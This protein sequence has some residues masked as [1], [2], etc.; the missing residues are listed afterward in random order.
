MSLFPIGITVPEVRDAIAFEN[1]RL[2]LNM[3]FEADRGDIIIFNYLL[4]VAGAFPV[5]SG[6]PV[7][8]R[9]ASIL[10]ECRGLTFCAHTGKVLARKF[11]KFF[12]V[13]ERPETQ[14]H[15]IDWWRPHH[16]LTK[17]DGSMLTPVLV[18]GEL[19]WHTKMGATDVATPAADFARQNPS[20]E[21]FARAL[22][23]G[24]YT[25]AAEWTSRKQRIVIDYPQDNIVF[26]AARDNFTGEYLPYDEL[27]SL[28]AVYDVPVVDALSSPVGDIEAFIAN[29]R[30]LKDI[31]G[32]VIAFAN[33]ER[34][35]VKADDYMRVHKAKDSI[36]LEKSVVAL[37]ANEQV[38]DLLAVLPESDRAALNEFHDLIE[39]GL[40]KKA[41]EINAIVADAKARM[42]K[43]E[44]AM[45][46]ASNYPKIKNFLFSVWDGRDANTV[47]RTHVLNNT[48]SQTRVD[49]VRH[50][51]GSARWTYGYGVVTGD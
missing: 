29:A 30:E 22:I 44:F 38:D 17:L 12:N 33:G 46:Q 11:Q 14:M 9:R 15:L 41:E 25:P 4:S 7:E 43:K 27:R 23:A 10:R 51:W 26:T 19:Q 45:T 20:Y 31:E 42:D 34:Y 47:L 21:A 16:I 13:N 28:C 50:L 35:K 5:P 8:D 3:F 36:I 18:N 49:E 39:V 6:D 24:G 40:A 37:I 48:G 32:Y 2:G 1:E